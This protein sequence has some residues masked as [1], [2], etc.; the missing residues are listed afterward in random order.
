[1]EAKSIRL[2][3]PHGYRF[4]RIL[5]S[6]VRLF[7]CNGVSKGKGGFRASPACIL[8]FRLGGQP[9]AALRHLVEFLD[10]RLAVVPGAMGD[11]QIRLLG[12][13]RVI[14]HDALPLSLRHIV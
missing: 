6:K 5:S 11:W 4:A 9:P 7:L 12:F 13:V 1:M 8:P 2:V 14:T 3:A 10:E